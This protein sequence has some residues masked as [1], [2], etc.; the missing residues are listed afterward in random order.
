MRKPLT[1]PEVLSSSISRVKLPRPA[2]VPANCGPEIKIRGKKRGPPNRVPCTNSRGWQQPRRVGKWHR[3]AA[4][5]SMPLH[6]R[7]DGLWTLESEWRPVQTPNGETFP[8]PRQVRNRHRLPLLRPTAREVSPTR[9]RHEARVKVQP[10]GNSY[11]F[12]GKIEGKAV[13]FLLVSGCTTNLI[14]RQLF[15]TLSARVRAEME[16]YNGEYGTLADRSCI[17]FYGIIELTGRVRDQAIRETFIVS[18][19]KE[20]AILGMPFLKRHGCHIDFSKSAMVMSGREL[21][22][23]NK[24]GRPR[25]GSTE[26]Y[27]TGPLPGY[28]SLQGE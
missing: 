20:D 24:F 26:L 21:A 25:P 17:P 27:D 4:T 2:D 12:L 5:L 15:D 19:L 22:C 7:F 3:P 23:V 9:V 1:L 11:F 18:Q 6:N 13:T 16:P 10:H 14:C 8:P 28:H